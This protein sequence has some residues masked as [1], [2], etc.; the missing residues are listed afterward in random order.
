MWALLCQTVRYSW[1][2]L[3]AGRGWVGKCLEDAGGVVSVSVLL[4]IYIL[5]VY[6]M[7]RK[8]KSCIK[9]SNVFVK[10]CLNKFRKLIPLC[11]KCCTIIPSFVKCWP[12]IYFVSFLDV[13]LWTY[14][15]WKLWLD[16]KL[17]VL[18]KN[19]PI[20]RN[21]R[22]KKLCSLNSKHTNILPCKM[23]KGNLCLIY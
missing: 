3:R 21:Y 23:P 13:S 2:L 7:E 15:F 5:W 19:I 9:F 14:F 18:H 12:F 11:V 20:L 22:G 1:S 6:C 8:K 4:V 17:Y 10:G 16:L